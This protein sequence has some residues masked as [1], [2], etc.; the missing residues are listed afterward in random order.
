M[1]QVWRERFEVS[2]GDFCHELQLYKENILQL[3]A[4]ILANDLP[5]PTGFFFGT[6]ADAS[7]RERD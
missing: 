3:K 2:D 6:D 5:A 7:C 1:E 4:D